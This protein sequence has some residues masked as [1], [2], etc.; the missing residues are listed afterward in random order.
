MPDFDS[1]TAVAETIQ[2]ALCL[3]SVLLL[4]HCCCWCEGQAT[5]T[6]T[7]EVHSDSC[8]LH[9]NPYNIWRTCIV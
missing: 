4:L 7:C 2:Q 8:V 6:D 9:M 3:E 5:E 1:S